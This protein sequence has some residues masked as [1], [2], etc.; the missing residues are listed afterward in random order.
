[1]L[2]NI[3]FSYIVTAA[4]VPISAE[5]L[6]FQVIFENFFKSGDTAQ[7]QADFVALLLKLG[8]N[9][10]QTSQLAAQI[11]A[12]SAV[13]KLNPD[14]SDSAKISVEINKFIASF[15]L[16]ISSQIGLETFQTDTDITLDAQF[17][18]FNALYASI[19]L[20]LKN[21]Q[22]NAGSAQEYFTTKIKG[23]FARFSLVMVE[24]SKK[25]AF[26]KKLTCK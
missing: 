9:S 12:L 2:V 11:K 7:T 18:E 19:I 1:L 10:A 8:A 16:L 20:E 14:A 23:K 4:P 22:I 21:I 26:K 17:T 13:L 24:S 25:A 15:E 5:E 3:I 6:S